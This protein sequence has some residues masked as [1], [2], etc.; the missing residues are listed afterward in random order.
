MRWN[1][2]RCE[3]SRRAE[4]RAA[5]VRQGP[6]MTRAARS[7]R[8][9]WSQG[10]HSHHQIATPLQC[11]D[12][13]QQRRAPWSGAALAPDRILATWRPENPAEKPLRVRVECRTVWT[14]A[15]E[16]AEWFKAHAWKA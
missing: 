5:F 6:V 14:L 15:G 2:S 13:P 10:D 12:A 7:A 11:P 16:M 4:R 9:E 8:A 3:P 1:G